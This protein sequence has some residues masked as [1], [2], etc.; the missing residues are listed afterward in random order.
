MGSVVSSP[1]NNQ[2]PK[3]FGRPFAETIVK[4][5]T[6][7]EATK[8]TFEKSNSADYQSSLNKNQTTSDSDKPSDKPKE[9]RQA[10][11]DSRET[12]SLM[13]RSNNSRKSQQ[14]KQSDGMKVKKHAAETKLSSGNPS[15]IPVVSPRRTIE[16]KENKHHHN[17]G[18]EPLKTINPNQQQ[19]GCTPS[20]GRRKKKSFKSVSS[21]QRKL[22]SAT[23]SREFSKNVNIGNRNHKESGEKSVEF[24]DE[25]NPLS[26]KKIQVSRIPDYCFVAPLGTLPPPK[27][28]H[29]EQSRMHQCHPTY[30]PAPIPHTNPTWTY[31]GGSCPDRS[32]YC[33]VPDF[34]APFVPTVCNTAV[35]NDNVDSDIEKDMHTNQLSP[36]KVVEAKSIE[37]HFS[38]ATVLGMIGD[39]P[40]VRDDLVPR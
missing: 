29:S 34:V 14:R 37:G 16:N 31:Q 17:R 15:D 6:S 13:K 5:Y 3:S 36:N 35:S 28:G 10:A 40:S 18:S 20:D 38:R 23:P 8:T 7:N 25:W 19:E 11:T 26:K 1:A 33:S 32:R 27:Y 9:S 2:P 30:Q 39:S 4:N 21:L 24:S 12:N 22:R